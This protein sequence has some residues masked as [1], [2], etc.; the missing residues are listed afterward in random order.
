M[1]D[2]QA[3]I[4]NKERE[5]EDAEEHHQVEIKVRKREG[6]REGERE[7]E[8]GREGEREDTVVHLFMCAVGVQAKSEAFVVRAPKQHHR[9]ETRR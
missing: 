6:G 9:T 7:R 2:A 3:T 5:L 8:R 4:R 1:E